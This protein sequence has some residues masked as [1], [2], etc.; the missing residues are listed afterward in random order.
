M[1]EALGAHVVKK[2]IDQV[3]PR[4]EKAS[5]T[6]DASDIYEQVQ[7]INRVMLAHGL[8]RAYWPEFFEKCEAPFSIKHS[9]LKGDDSLLDWLD[10]EKLDWICET[11]LIDRDWLNGGEKRPHQYFNFSNNPNELVMTLKSEF[12]KY[13]VD[14]SSFHNAAFLLNSNSEK[15]LSAGGT[16][17]SVAYGIPICRLGG[18]VFVTRWI[19]DAAAGG[20]PWDSPKYQ[21]QL[22]I[23]AR[24]ARNA[25]EMDTNW[26]L[27]KIC[28]FDAY[29]SG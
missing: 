16:R 12:E 24:I 2:L 15:A 18:E 20:Y 10:N 4:S 19:V 27:L 26:E 28:D 1:W 14:E 25:Y 21:P 8:K 7:R 9:D 13:P 29:H 22:R 17:V 11:F 3:W 5:S 23:F 6:K